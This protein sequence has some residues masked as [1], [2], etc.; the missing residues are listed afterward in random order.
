MSKAS[1][2]IDLKSL[3]VAGQTATN[4]LSVDSSG[5]MIYDGS[6]GTQTPSNP[7]VNTNNVFIDPDSLDIRKGINV[8]ATFSAEETRVGSYEGSN[9]MLS[10]RGIVAKKSDGSEYFNVGIIGNE[11]QYISQT[12][13]SYASSSITRYLSGSGATEEFE[14][15][16][17]A[18]ADEGAFGL[19]AEW[20]ITYKAN[21]TDTDYRY[22]AHM[23]C[24]YSHFAK[25]TSYTHKTRY[26]GLT[27][28]E[29]EYRSGSN[30]YIYC[31]INPRVLNTDF[32]HGWRLY[33]VFFTIYA[34]VNT[35]APAYSFGINT[36]VS[37]KLGFAIGNGTI[38]SEA[39]LAMGKYNVQ[40]TNDDYALIIGNGVDDNNRSNALTVDWNGNI[41]TSGNITTLNHSSAIGTVISKVGATDYTTNI[42]SGTETW[43]SIGYIEVTVGRYILF[44]RARFNPTSSGAHYSDINVSTTSASNSNRDRRY[45]TGTYVNQHNY[46]TWVDITESN[47]DENGLCKIYLNGYS[48]VAGEWVRNNVNGFYL[49]AMRIM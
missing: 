43:K 2:S 13:S 25:G 11:Q 21:S 40:D 33:S 7:D 41:I 20:T 27:E 12:A 48:T 14:N 32:P 24:N 5:I 36:D 26:Q 19:R 9:I 18:I 3:N 31:Y 23:T 28:M 46:S 17:D 44:A 35:T 39:G 47:V 4:F 8:L 37:K 34:N 10:N 45:G 15:L 30:A 49:A 42:S 22:T 38:P 16:Y 29:V 6:N 1:G